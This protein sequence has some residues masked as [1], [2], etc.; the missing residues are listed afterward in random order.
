MKLWEKIGG[1]YS[2]RKRKGWPS[3]TKSGGKTGWQRHKKE[4]YT[5]RSYRVVVGGWKAKMGTKTDEGKNETVER[6][7]K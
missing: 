5:Y 1:L 7:Y 3:N 4:T 6:P 2:R